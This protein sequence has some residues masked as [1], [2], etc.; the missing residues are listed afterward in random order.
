MRQM[1]DK[2]VVSHW[3]SLQKR[4]R[5]EVA[6]AVTDYCVSRTAGEVASL[7]ERK[8]SWVTEHL[9]LHACQVAAGV[10]AAD[11]HVEGF[12]RD[13]LREVAKQFAPAEPDEDYVA[14]Y[15][16]EGHTPE[17]ARCLATAYEAGENAIE[18]GVI[19]ETITK[20][21]ERAAKIILPSGTDWTMRLRR[22]VSDVKSAA[23]LLND[24]KIND[25]KRSVTRKQV[26]IADEL[27]KEQMERVQNLHIA[28]S[29]EGVEPQ[30]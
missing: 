25:L 30:E 3:A 16:A 11:S 7:L 1:T 23:R 28:F 20:Q 13:N 4:H 26:A 8:V 5:G 17:V 22:A 14:E 29:D 18:A 21:N 15:E 9:Q 10:R 2:E 27:W 24:A 12:T 19:Q 6:R